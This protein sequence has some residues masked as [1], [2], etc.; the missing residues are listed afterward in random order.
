MSPDWRNLRPIFHT[1]RSVYFTLL[2]VKKNTFGRRQ[3]A[4]AALTVVGRITVWR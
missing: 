2:Q 1:F 4:C 3:T